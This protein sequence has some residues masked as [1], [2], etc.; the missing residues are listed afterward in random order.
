VKDDC[1]CCECCYAEGSKEVS[2]CTSW[3]ALTRKLNELDLDSEQRVRLEQFLT[4]KQTV[5][6]LNAEDFEKIGELGAGNGGVVWQVLHKKTGLT[7]ARKVHRHCF[8]LHCTGFQLQLWP[9][10]SH[11][12][13]LSQNLSLGKILVRFWIL[14]GFAK[15][16][17]LA[18]RTI[19]RAFGTLCCLSVCLSSVCDILL[20]HSGTS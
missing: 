15:C 12:C 13:I 19:G 20:W 17:F 5:G 1:G 11:F 16:H 4:Q 2:G 3:E 10:S 14:A 9:K 7:M 18:D 6:E 8:L